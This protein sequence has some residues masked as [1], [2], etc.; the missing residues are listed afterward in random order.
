MFL[1]QISDMHFRSHGRKLYDFIDVNAC[2]A[3]VVSQLNAL[4][5]RPDAVIITG[6]IVN[7]GLASEYQVAR[8]TLSNLHYPLY[9][10]PGNHDDK[11][12][13]LE[14]MGPLCPLLGTDPQNMHYAVDDFDMRLLFID[15]SVPGESK[16]WL[17]LETL[18]WLEA[19]LEQGGDKPTAVFMHHPPMKLGS[20]QMDRIARTVTNCWH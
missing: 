9:I 13:F 3:E 8:R 19:Q 11:A 2:N 14:S 18:S 1:A 20:A 12:Q 4:E 17:T 15:T 16:G 10:I 7:C 6:D 5:E